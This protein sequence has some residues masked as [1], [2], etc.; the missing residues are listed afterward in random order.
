MLRFVWCAFLL[1][2]CGA[3][4]VPAD[5]AKTSADAN[6]DR[7]R[8][9]AQPVI[10]FFGWGIQD[11]EG[12]YHDSVEHVSAAGGAA[13]PAILS[14]E[15]TSSD[16]IAQKLKQFATKL[17]DLNRDANEVLKQQGQV[18]HHDLKQELGARQVIRSI[19]RSPAA[20][21]ADCYEMRKIFTES[22]Q[23][24]APG[25]QVVA[26]A[27]QKWGI[28]SNEALLG[29]TH[30]VATK[31]FLLFDLQHQLVRLYVYQ[32]ADTFMDGE[33]T[34]IVIQCPLSATSKLI[35]DAE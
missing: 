11:Y 4:Q 12:R 5:D 9:D 16:R 18:K 34:E 35:K 21:S 13:L 25:D 26:A 29:R 27:W 20:K 32:E 24:T 2:G 30:R 17:I 1:I 6:I 10:D 15:Q 7:L 23:V 3:T 14:T 31:A 8:L 22:K 28:V 19:T 33:L